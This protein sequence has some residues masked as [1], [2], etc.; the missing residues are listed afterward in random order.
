MLFNKLQNTVVLT[1]IIYMVIVDHT[2]GRPL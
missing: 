1:V 2:K